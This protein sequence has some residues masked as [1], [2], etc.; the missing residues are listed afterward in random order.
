[1]R[2][3][4]LP[5]PQICRATIKTDITGDLWNSTVNKLKD[6]NDLIQ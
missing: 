6:I 1:M 4:N 2:R 5:S 3:I